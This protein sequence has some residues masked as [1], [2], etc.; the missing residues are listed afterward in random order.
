VLS[1]STEKIDRADKLP[2]YAREGVG[3]AW[4]V[5][6]LQ[7][8]LEAWLESG[9]WLALGVCHDDAR[10]RIEPFDALEL[11]LALLWADLAQP[12]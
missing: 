10:A 11:D 4:L 3:H 1:P 12:Q 7:R 9:R 6:P 2:I 8:M 5:N